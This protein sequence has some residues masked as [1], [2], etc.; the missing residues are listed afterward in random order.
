MKEHSIDTKVTVFENQSELNEIERE[1]MTQASDARKNAHAPYSNF[2]VGASLLLDN[3]KILVGSNQE[4]AAYPSGLCAERVVLF[5]AGANY[6]QNK[7][8]KIFITASP[9]NQLSLIPVAPC[10]SCRQSIAEYETNQKNN[11]EIYFMGGKGEI[12]KSESIM[13]LLPFMFTK[14]NL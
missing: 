3:G 4:N 8:L 5:Y 13:N 10:G 2:L 6:P 1:L 14:D 12:Y 11:I 7:I 9:R